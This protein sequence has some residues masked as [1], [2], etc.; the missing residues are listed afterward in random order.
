MVNSTTGDSTILL[1][2]QNNNGDSLWGSQTLKAGDFN[3]DNKIDSTD[4]AGFLSVYNALVVGANDSNRNYDVNLDNK[5]TIEDIALVL[6]NYNSLTV[7][8]D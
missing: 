1:L 2:P 4:F 8:G 3:N 7:P 6:A 5:I